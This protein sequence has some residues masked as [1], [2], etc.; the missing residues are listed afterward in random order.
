MV[1]R[2]FSRKALYKKLTWVVYIVYRQKMKWKVPPYSI[3]RCSSFS[4]FTLFRVVSLVFR[5]LRIA[6]KQR[7]HRLWFKIA[8]YFCS[9]HHKIISVLFDFNKYQKY[10]FGNKQIINSSFMFSCVYLFFW[11][12]LRILKLEK[13]PVCIL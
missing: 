10:V 4:A 8:K 5:I 12:N 1:F 3:S 9:S 7:D 6:V 13:G 11:Y 2:N